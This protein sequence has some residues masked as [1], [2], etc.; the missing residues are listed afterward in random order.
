MLRVRSYLALGLGLA[1]TASACGADADAPDQ[2]AAPSQ[3]VGASDEGGVIPADAGGVTV[4]RGA[5]FTLDAYA[6]RDVLFWFWA[7]W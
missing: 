3:E 2:S 1:L 7:P 4:L 5:D 6:G